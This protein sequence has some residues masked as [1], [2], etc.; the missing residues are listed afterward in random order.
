MAVS[1]EL[2][3][4]ELFTTAR[5][6]HVS[7][8]AI[9]AM[10]AVPVLG[11]VAGALVH[12]AAGIVTPL[13]NALR[14]GQTKDAP[15]APWL[16]RAAFNAGMLVLSAAAGGQ[17]YVL[18]GGSLKGQI[19]LL[20]VPPLA[21]AAAVDALTNVAILIGV[22]TLQTGRHPLQIFRQD[23]QWG[24][25]INI[26]GAIMGGGAL[27]L[28][29]SWFH[30]IGLA[31]FFL[32]ILATSYSLRLYVTNMRQYVNRLEDANAELEEANLGLLETLG[33][34]IDADDVY[35]YGHSN[36]VA[37]Y[38]E[39]IAQEM[40]LP[41]DV[42]TLIVRAALVHDLGKVGVMDNI[43]GKPGPLTDEEY[44][45]MRRHP[46]IGA[47]IAGRMKG[48]QDLV[49]GVRYHHERWDGRGYPDGLAGEELPLL[50]RVL[51][52]ADTLD[53]MCSDR[54]YRPTRSLKDVR[55]EI[56]RCSGSQFNPE[57]VSAFLRVLDR[58]D[59]GFFRNSAASVDRSVLTGG[60]DHRITDARYLKRSML[61]G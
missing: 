48:L 3:S 47:E 25:P 2:L 45:I 35:T 29:Y 15:R 41:R 23:I 16:Q 8:S 4:A 39:A 32:P 21:L 28:A 22:L 61:A 1:A 30:Y 9:V 17:A 60:M 56:E 43:V 13:A 40:G 38:A 55:M 50:A 10:A 12:M 51:A 46:L 52:V 54:P 36:Q 24:L 26:V 44:N 18:A 33:A 58:K 14:P 53:A 27:A 37:V 49:P 34:V 11:P 20:I 42:R 57:V 59:A 31:V 5:G 19:T 7:V 6:S